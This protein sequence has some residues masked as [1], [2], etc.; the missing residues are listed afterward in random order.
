[1][2]RNSVV[3]KTTALNATDSTASQELPVLATGADGT[4]VML[5][6]EDACAFDMNDSLKLRI[7]VLVAAS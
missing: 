2:G 6:G 3:Q 1:M 4:E 5:P 7:G